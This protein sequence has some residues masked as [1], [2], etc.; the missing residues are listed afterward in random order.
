MYIAHIILKPYHK[1][2]KTLQLSPPLIALCALFCSAMLPGLSGKWTGNLIKGDST[3]YPLTYNFQ[4]IGDS[5][6]GTAKSELGEFPIEH[7]KLDSSV[8][9]FKVTVNGLDILHQGTVYSDS[10]SMNI[11]VNGSNVHC[12]LTR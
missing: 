11:N 7:G 1:E 5:V 12:T 6:I 3:Y 4:T 2:M 10:I 9:H 8:L